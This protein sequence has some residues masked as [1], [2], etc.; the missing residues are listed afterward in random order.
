MWDVNISALLLSW[1]S[2]SG[3]VEKYLIKS[4]MSMI[5]EVDFIQNE[6]KKK[7]FTLAFFAC[8]LVK[9]CALL[10]YHSCWEM[11]FLF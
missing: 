2:K 3:N 1:I 7:N 4:S 11:T 6:T 10:H 9:T 8:H 5:S